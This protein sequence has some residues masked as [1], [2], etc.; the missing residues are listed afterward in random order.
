MDSTALIQ[1]CS[2]IPARYQYSNSE[3]IIDTIYARHRDHMDGIIDALSR[4]QWFSSIVYKTTESFRYLVT[5]SGHPADRNMTS[6]PG[7]ESVTLE[8]ISCENILH[9][10]Y[11]FL[12][13]RVESVK[14]ANLNIA[15]IP[16]DDEIDEFFARLENYLQIT[17]KPCDLHVSLHMARHNFNATTISAFDRYQPVKIRNRIIFTVP[18]AKM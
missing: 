10:A 9:F 11:R 15:E 18:A 1:F 14:L 5:M 13:G 12:R 2:T 3:L 6:C 7:L 8:D 16:D 4:T 17:P